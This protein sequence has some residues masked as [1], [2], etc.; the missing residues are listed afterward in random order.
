MFKKG[1]GSNT[2]FFVCDESTFVKRPKERMREDAP[3]EMKV[4][5]F[6]DN[7][8]YIQGYLYAKVVMTDDNRF[9]SLIGHLITVDA[10]SV[11]NE[12]CDSGFMASLSFK[13]DCCTHWNFY[14]EDY[15]EGSNADSYYHLCG[16]GFPRFI[17][18]MGLVGHIVKSQP[19]ACRDDNLYELDV[20]DTDKLLQQYRIIEFSGVP[21]WV[22]DKVLKLKF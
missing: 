14:G 22:E 17:A 9:L 18:F 21:H 20:I 11:T 4:Y 10:W 7:F 8:G 16:S 6:E 19:N 13:W 5:A 12:P 15:S 3:K 2:E 1:R